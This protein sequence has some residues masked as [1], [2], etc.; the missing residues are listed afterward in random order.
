[1]EKT[2]KQ[3]ELDGRNLAFNVA[4]NYIDPKQMDAYLKD[5]EFYT[6]IPVLDEKPQELISLELVRSQTAQLRELRKEQEQVLAN[7]EKIKA[8]L[9]LT[10]QTMDKI[11]P[12]GADIKVNVN[13]ISYLSGKN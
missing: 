7:E 5:V 1:M 11:Y 9:E 10:K 4:K 12:A 8:A 6:N 3:L 2:I 13:D